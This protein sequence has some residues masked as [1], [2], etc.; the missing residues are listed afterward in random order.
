MIKA[1]RREIRTMP[2]KWNF[3]TKD[4]S[5]TAQWEQT[6]LVTTTGVEVLTVSEKSPAPPEIVI[7]LFG[8]SFPPKT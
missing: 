4:L 2:D 5:Q 7:P 6:E 1:G 8:R 3:K